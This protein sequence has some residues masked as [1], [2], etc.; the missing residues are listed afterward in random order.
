MFILVF[1]T[2]SILPVD[3]NAIICGNL[4][5]M[6]NLYEVI[7]DI[8]NAEQCRE[9]FRSMKQAIHQ[10]FWNEEYGCWFDYD[11][12]HACHV[13]LYMDTNFFPLFSG[14]THDG[15]IVSIC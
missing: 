1:R 3:L 7:D 9:Q 2:S 13:N 6:A 11:I 8:S 5:L 4:R 15:T 12:I 10:V 14:C